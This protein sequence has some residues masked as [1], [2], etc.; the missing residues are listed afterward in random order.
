MKTTK[1]VALI[2]TLALVALGYFLIL[3]LYNIVRPILM[4]LEV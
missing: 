2:Y 4:A 1:I 3:G